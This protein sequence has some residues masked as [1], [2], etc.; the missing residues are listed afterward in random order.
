MDI[1]AGP[2]AGEITI[3]CFSP[4]L[5]DVN[6]SFNILSNL[7]SNAGVFVVKQKGGIKDS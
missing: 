2:S 3:L 1:S 6:P 5:G 4:L 7:H